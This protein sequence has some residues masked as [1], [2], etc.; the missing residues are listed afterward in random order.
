MAHDPNIHED[1]PPEQTIP[2]DP[3][4]FLR[5]L[6]SDDAPGWLTIWLW[7]TKHTQWFR[8]THLGQAAA[9]AVKQAQDCDVYFGVGL[10][11][12]RLM[13]GRGESDDVLVLP[14]LYVDIDLKHQ[15]HK[16]ANLPETTE[17]A[18][19]LLADAIPLQPTVLVDSGHGL[20]GYWL[21]RELWIL[22]T[23]EERQAAAHLLQR[24][25]RTIQETAKAHG[26]HVDGT[27]DLA[28]V[29]RIPGTYNHKVA[30]E[31]REVTIR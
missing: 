16:A 25:Q 4:T 13:K 14:G 28:R 22:E 7:P 31:T 1:G 12:E 24:F 20:H 9:Y 11:K 30:G 10:R 3:L 21:F 15:T 5:W 27:G 8:A 17:D 18:R 6:Y 2:Q 19:Q 23:A 29:L 26:W